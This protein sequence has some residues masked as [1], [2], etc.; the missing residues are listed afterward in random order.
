MEV[1]PL[2]E[3]PGLA[4]LTNQRMGFG[5]KGRR[6]AGNNVTG[7]IGGAGR[8]LLG[9]VQPVLGVPVAGR[10]LSRKRWNIRGNA[11]AQPS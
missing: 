6:P 5:G 11:S 7:A 9:E 8:R 3:Q 10:R 1:G 4:L 2:Q